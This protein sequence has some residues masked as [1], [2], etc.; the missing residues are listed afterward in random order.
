MAQKEVIRVEMSLESMIEDLDR[1]DGKIEEFEER[2]KSVDKKMGKVKKTGKKVS[3]T[4]EKMGDGFNAAAKQL[5]SFGNR[6]LYFGASWT[7]G[8][9][10]PLQRA[11]QDAVETFLNIEREWVGAVKAMDRPMKD[12]K[13]DFQDLTR[14]ISVEFGVAQAE[15]VESLASF[16]KAG[17]DNKEVLEELLRVSGLVSVNFDTDLANATDIVRVAML[18]WGWQAEDVQYGLSA[19]NEI[20]D[21]TATSEL[22]L[23]EAFT[24]VGSQ[25]QALNIDVRDLGGYLAAMQGRGI[26]ARVAATALKTT[27]VNLSQETGKLEDTLATMGVTMSESELNSLSTTEKID[28]LASSYAGFRSELGLTDGE[29]KEWGQKLKDSEGD[30][31]SQNESLN[32]MSA[33][34]GDLVGKRHVS[35][36]IALMDDMANGV[37][38]NVNTSSEYAK[39]MGAV[40]MSNEE[41]ADTLENK[42]GKALDSAPKRFDKFISKIEVAKEQIGALIFETL[43]PFLDKIVGLLDR[44]NALDDGVKRNLVSFGLVVAAI[45]PI[46]ITIAALVKGL[47]FVFSGFSMLSGALGAVAGA[48]GL[49]SAPIWAVVGII[50]AVVGVVIKLVDLFKR[51][52]ESFKENFIDRLDP[53]VFEG[54]K[55]AFDAFKEGFSEGFSSFGLGGLEGGVFDAIAKGFQK[56]AEWVNNV[57]WENVINSA[58]K[59]GKILGV[60]AKAVGIV[61]GVLAVL[62]VGIIA[63]ATVVV[64]AVVAI[65]G[66]II[67]VITNLDLVWQ[68]IQGM[69]KAIGDFFVN[70]YNQIT[71]WFGQMWS[72]ISTFFSTIWAT[73]SGFFM[74]IINTVIQW[75]VGFITAIVTWGTNLITTVL[76]ILNPILVM[77][78]TIFQAIQSVVNLV[79]T[80][81][82]AGIIIV[83]RAVSNFIMTTWTAIWGFLQPIL[84]T[85]WNF[86]K[87]TFQS[88]LDFIINTFNSVKNALINAWNFIMHNV[89]SPALNW[90][91]TNIINRIRDAINGMINRFNDG[92]NKANQ[93]FQNMKDA[94]SNKLNQIKSTI[95]STIDKAVQ[96]IINLATE[97]ITWGKDMIDGF[98]N[99]VTQK[100]G[101]LKAKVDEIAQSVRDSVGFSVPKEGP[102]SDADTYM[103][104]MID[105]FIAGID[106]DERRLVGRVEQLASKMSMA[107]EG[108]QFGGADINARLN[109]S[110][111][112]RQITELA[113]PISASDPIVKH[114]AKHEHYEVRPGVMIASDS[115]QREF[116][117]HVEKIKR[118]EDVRN[119][120]EDK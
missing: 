22:E 14:A 47:A 58:K 48:F 97:A 32:N 41:L 115:E 55:K 33:A 82:L 10:Y 76:T 66:G 3:N 90:I 39:A 86:I 7:A 51:L 43:E 11:G 69:F 52:G 4:F 73:I 21:N 87:S 103:P 18:Q 105:L 36:V 95:K 15:A 92:K 27:F 1:I 8:V 101:Q 118:T 96:P 19:I 2:L 30:F 54:I 80:L 110:G 5:D 85:I 79:M 83:W 53:K 91:R 59:F 62:V 117:R 71:S 89:I 13:A 64:V 57:D 106:S 94:I 29:F 119:S 104:D 35:K 49:A 65:I 93:A 99:G 60:I 114:V 61:I 109:T 107:V 12:L 50:L 98:I 31:K 77:F 70:L 74:N 17:F 46:V 67:W 88:V 112:E 81:I 40:N 68:A 28:V 63:V 78:S 26:E 45:G 38:G 16:A 113:T 42:A 44:F 9:S 75:G 116:V 23:G 84:M 34:F 120:K 20:A 6:L 24:I 72:Q 56:L 102:L 100:A 37:D 108:K 111:F 25:A